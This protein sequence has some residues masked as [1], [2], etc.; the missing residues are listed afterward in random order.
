MQA[1]PVTPRRL[2]YTR[3]M[4]AAAVE[5]DRLLRLLRGLHAEQWRAPTDCEGWDVHDV[6]AH[7]VGAAAAMASLASRCGRHGGPAGSAG[8]TTSSISS[9]A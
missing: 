9:T 4:T 7:L 6:V 2:T 3:W 8:T 5:Y 1:D